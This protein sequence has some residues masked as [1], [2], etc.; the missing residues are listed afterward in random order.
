MR[1]DSQKRAL[2]TDTKALV[3][4]ENECKH[5]SLK[6]GGKPTRRVVAVAIDMRSSIA[7]FGYRWETPRIVRH[8]GALSRLREQI[9]ATGCGGGAVTFKG[10]NDVSACAP[11]VYLIR[12]VN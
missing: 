6:G 3:H 10:F 5:H 7:C 12:S 2:S 1:P 11:T 8:P 9:A 4:L